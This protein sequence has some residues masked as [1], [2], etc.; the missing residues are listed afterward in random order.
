MFGGRDVIIAK[1]K[2]N[3]TINKSALAFLLDMFLAA[4]VKIPIFSRSKFPMNALL[5]YYFYGL[6]AFVLL[7]STATWLEER[8]VSER[9]LDAGLL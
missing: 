2:L 1:A 6:G 5:N 4:L 7:Y 9:L 8:A 3:T